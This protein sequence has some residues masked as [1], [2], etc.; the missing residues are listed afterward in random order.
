MKCNKWE[1]FMALRPPYRFTFRMHENI[2]FSFSFCYFVENLIIRFFSRMN[3]RNRRNGIE[4]SAYVFTGGGKRASKINCLLRLCYFLF[5]LNILRYKSI[6]GEPIYNILFRMERKIA[7]L[8]VFCLR[9]RLIAASMCDIPHHNAMFW[10]DKFQK[11]KIK[12]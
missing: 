7:F 2:Y 9:W 4:F 1:Y 5:Q 6:R 11:N 10:N 12:F 3:N 8:M